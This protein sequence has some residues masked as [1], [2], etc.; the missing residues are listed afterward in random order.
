MQKE[1]FEALMAL[2]KDKG[3]DPDSLL[4]GIKQA[5]MKAAEQNF[6][7]SEN[8]VIDVNKEEQTLDVYRYKTV[9]EKVEKGREDLE[10]SLEAARDVDPSA[11]LGDLVYMELDPKDFSRIAAQNGKS[12]I[13]QKIREEERNAHDKFFI[14]NEKN[15]LTGIVQKMLKPGEYVISFGDKLDGKIRED[16]LIPGEKLK[17]G[18]HIKVYLQIQK[19]QK[20]NFKSQ[21]GEKTEKR[22]IVL[23]RKASMLVKKLFETE[24]AEIKEG[25]VEVKNIAREPGSR[26]KM[27]VMSHNEKV[28]PIGACIGVNGARIE[29]VCNELNGEKIDVILWDENPANF[30]EKALSPAKVIAI[31]ADPDEKAALVIVPDN[32]LSLAI[33]M[34]GQ[35]ARL[36]AK[37]TGYKI[38]IKS[39]TQA[40][41]EGLFDETEEEEVETADEGQEQ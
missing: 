35:N 16:D 13:M 41:E 24:V 7:T 22:R 2:A 17:V 4:E 18:Q 26:T 12:I 38:D 30:V 25:I 29:A 39:E 40:H 11:E 33:G 34:K 8:I 15:M 37:L 23:T 21:D 10:C 9:V 3:I 28:D 36:A 32:Q 19:D 1:F 31:A 27:A 20:D 6:G 5:L 14:D